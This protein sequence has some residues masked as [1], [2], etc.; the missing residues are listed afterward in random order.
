M[1]I[2]IDEVTR[3]SLEELESD[4]MY[5]ETIASGSFG[6]VIRAIQLSDNKEVAIKIL[7]KDSRKFDTIQIKQEISI[8]K[9]LDH[10]NIV[11]FLS[12][13]ETNSKLYIIME[14]I[15]SGTLQH[16]IDQHKGPVTE[17]EAS[18]ILQ[19]LISAVAYLH[20]KDICH[21]DIKPDN[22]MFNR[23]NDVNSLQ[24]IDFGLSAGNFNGFEEYDY[25]GT[26][27]YMAPEQIEQK[28]YS[29]YVDLWSIGIIMYLM[30]NNGKHPYFVQGDHK[31]TYIQK[32]KN[33]VLKMVNQIS[34]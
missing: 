30:L 7:S 25:C 20:S 3:S 10:P 34:E 21:R 2:L 4:F 1:E 15:P 29:K 13:T 5:K 27:I 23:R 11:Q 19:Q 8:L 12:Y 33:S 32:I 9:Q 6:T 28:S 26:F 22:I 14:Y 16:W 18:I 24:L 31:R 17:T